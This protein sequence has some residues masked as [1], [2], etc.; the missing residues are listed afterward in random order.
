MHHFKTE[1][2]EGTSA[3]DHLK[4]LDRPPLGLYLKNDWTLEAQD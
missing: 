4:D 1:H 2:V 3:P